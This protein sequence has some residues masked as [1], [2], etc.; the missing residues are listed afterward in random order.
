MSQKG[1]SVSDVVE[2]HPKL[3]GALFTVALLLTQAGSAAAAGGCAFNG[4]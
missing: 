1:S 2:S 4:L 3:L